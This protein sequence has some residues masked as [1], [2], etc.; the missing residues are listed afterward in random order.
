MRRKVDFGEPALP[1]PFVHQP[2]QDVALLPVGL[3]LLR[4]QGN[5]EN[6]VGALGQILEDLLARAPQQDRRELFMDA[7]QAAVADQV[8][9]LVLHAVFV[10]KAEGRPETAAIDELHYGEE[11]LQL[12][13]ERRAGQHKGIPALQLL[14]GARR[15]GS[16]VPYALRFVE[17]DQVGRQFV[18]VTHVFEDQFI[19]GEVEERW[20][21]HTTPS[22]AAAVRQ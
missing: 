8:A 19:A 5:A 18:H 1:L 13:F 12:V 7:V 20:A 22:A 3:R 4:G 9:F 6:L 21:R 11:F 10:Q 2:G 17:D 14:D 15:G 16:P